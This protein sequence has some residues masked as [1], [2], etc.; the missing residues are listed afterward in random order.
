MN[1]N[2]ECFPDQPLFL[3][4]RKLNESTVRFSVGEESC[5]VDYLVFYDAFSIGG[6][7]FFERMMDIDPGNN[8]EWLSYLEL[9]QS[10]LPN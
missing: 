3:G 5:T 2:N 4:L 7:H 10:L 9:A 8:A 6:L 1:H